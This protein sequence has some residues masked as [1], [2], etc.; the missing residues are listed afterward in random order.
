MVSI[1]GSGD[2]GE[3]KVCRSPKSVGE[4]GGLMFIGPKSSVVP[5]VVVVGWSVCTGI[6]MTLV[7][8]RGEGS[9]ELRSL[10]GE[11]VLCVVHMG[12]AVGPFVCIG[13]AIM[14]VGGGGEG[15][16][17]LRSPLEVRG[18]SV[19]SMAVVA[20]PSVSAGRGVIERKETA[21]CKDRHFFSSSPIETQDTSVSEERVKTT[22][23]L[24]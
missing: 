16:K 15:F 6:A 24:L 10:L 9:M 13:T 11:M 17:A 12:A 21:L 23:N 7:G 3:S 19:V 22:K 2:T 20:G 14:L 5:I 18:S 1:P 4:G 8:E